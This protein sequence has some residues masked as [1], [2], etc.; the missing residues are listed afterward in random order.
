MI[1]I[2][3]FLSFLGVVE[4][5]RRRTIEQDELE[6][7]GRPFE[8][9]RPG[10]GLYANGEI[11]LIWRDSQGVL[12]FCRIAN[13]EEIRYIMLYEMLESRSLTTIVPG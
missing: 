3:K 5:T 11:R 8:W 10:R 9:D 1:S 4:P 6:Y 7:K 13:D 2:T 12:T